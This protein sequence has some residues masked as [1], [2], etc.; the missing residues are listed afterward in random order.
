MISPPPAT[1]RA[2]VA[3]TVSLPAGFR[4]APANPTHVVLVARVIPAATAPGRATP[5]AL[6]APIDSVPS[7]ASPAQP[8]R[9]ILDTGS[10]LQPR[11]SPASGV[12]DASAGAAR[13]YTGSDLEA[14]LS[15]HLLDAP[16]TTAAGGR[17]LL[18]NPGVAEPS[19]GTGAPALASSNGGTHIVLMDAAQ[20]AGG[21]PAPVSPPVTN[22]EVIQGAGCYTWWCLTGA[23]ATDNRGNYNYTIGGGVNL[24]GRPITGSITYGQQDLYAPNMSTTLAVGG[25]WTQSLSYGPISFRGT[26]QV[27]IPMEQ[28]PTLIANSSGLAGQLAM[29]AFP[30]YFPPL[31]PTA[32]IGGSVTL[33]GSGLL[34]AFP[35]LA[36]IVPDSVSKYLDKLQYSRGGY[37]S[38]NPDTGDWTY[39]DTYAGK[40]Q[41]TGSDGY[42]VGYVKIPTQTS[43]SDLAKEAADKVFGGST[44]QPSP[45]D[46]QPSPAA[47]QPSPADAQPSPA[48][49]QP[50]PADVQPSPADVQPS[51]ADV[52]PSPADVQPSPADAQPSPADVQ[53]SPADAQPSQGA[54]AP[55]PADAQPSPGDAQPSSGDGQP[56]PGD[57]QPSLADANLPSP[58]GSQPSTDGGQ[59]GLG[60]G[61]GAAGDPAYGAAADSVYGQAGVGSPTQLSPIGAGLSSTDM[62]TA[63]AAPAIGATADGSPAGSTPLGGTPTGNAWGGTTSSSGGTSPYGNQGSSGSTS[64]ATA[65]SGGN[66]YAGTSGG[67]TASGGTSYAGNSGGGTASG[68]NS[69]AGTSGSGTASGGTSYAGTSGG[70]TSSGGATSGGGTSSGSTTSGSTSSG[71]HSSGGTTSATTSSSG[72]TSA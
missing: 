49:P 46:A 52:Q 42:L 45:S 51:P 4:H 34:A 61:P 15:A 33:K 6:L 2:A 64:T 37:Y 59:R 22:V 70:S 48:A 66:F 71:S 36:P 17:V 58:I 47:S 44:P 67:G 19:A 26:A 23:Q 60:T 13:A 65:R 27:E 7:P 72:T 56:S 53:P 50:S 31:A 43:L 30:D 21:P 25:L 63:N 8:L 28:V 18:G 68:G 5:P 69:Y 57:A 35:V 54:A 12:T 40:L 55:G 1:A 24:S 29:W 10:L 11:S 62:N 32:S 14:P 38:Y 9:A 20:P 41:I 3:A 39:R 16:G